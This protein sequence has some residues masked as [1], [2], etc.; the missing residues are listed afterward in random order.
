MN[1][2]G[3]QKLRKTRAMNT[4]SQLPTLPWVWGLQGGGNN[5][6][7]IAAVTHW[8][9][10]YSSPI[11]FI[12][13]LESL[14]LSFLLS[15]QTKVFI[16][17]LQTTLL[18]QQRR[19]GFLVSKPRNFCSKKKRNKTNIDFL[20]RLMKQIYNHLSLQ[21]LKFRPSSFSSDLTPK[22]PRPIS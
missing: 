22:G 13:G 10:H 15:I 17:T 5:G 2:L 4:M 6:G 1:L 3:L 11:F 8:L 7:Y 21:W 12:G 9:P 16:K 14:V 19:V 18:I 20:C